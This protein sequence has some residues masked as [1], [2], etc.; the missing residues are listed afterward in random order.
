MKNFKYIS[1]LLVLMIVY[2]SLP[3]FNPSFRNEKEATEFLRK[4]IITRADKVLF[5]APQ[6]VTMFICQ[7]SAGGKMKKL[8]YRFVIP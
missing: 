5:V 1:I 8:T 3:A 2:H 6:T 4:E 7:R